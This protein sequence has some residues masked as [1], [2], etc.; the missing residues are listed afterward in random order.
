V[1]A[2]EPSFPQAP[3]HSPPYNMAPSRAKNSNTSQSSHPS[4]LLIPST[5]DDDATSIHSAHSDQESDSEDDQILQG[6]RSTLELNEHDLAVLKEEEEREKLLTR[7]RSPVDGLRRVFSGGN[8]LPL[9]G[10][11][12]RIGKRE[13]RRQRRRDRRAKRGRQGED[14]QLMFE[15]E[16][17]YRDADHDGSGTSTPGSMD[18]GLGKGKW[19]AGEGRQ[20]GASLFVEND[21]SRL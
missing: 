9:D 14:G 1:V 6:A 5:Y 20:V 2:L 21:M 16:E 7:S 15:M 18:S 17:G 12:V 4:R 19:D 10:G 3:F 11:S 8:A 13:K